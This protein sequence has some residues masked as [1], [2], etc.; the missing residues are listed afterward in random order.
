MF[1]P[2]TK[3]RALE[4][5]DSLFGKALTTLPVVG[6]G[7]EED[8]GGA[9]LGGTY[10]DDPLPLSPRISRDVDGTRPNEPEQEHN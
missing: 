3:G 8:I 2:E 10:E 6:D 1:Y 7:D 9:D 5:M 4:D